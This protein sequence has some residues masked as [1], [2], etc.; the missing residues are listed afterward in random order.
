MPKKLYVGNLSFGATEDSIKT[1]FTQYG[2]VVSVKIIT[3]S[4]SGRSRGFG[5]VEME[6]AD[7]AIAA[8]NNQQ[9]EGRTLTV[10]VAREKTEGGRS[11][12]SGGFGGGSRGGFGGGRDNRNGGGG[13]GGGGNG[14]GG[15]ERW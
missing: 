8:L 13:N 2:E 9:F 1:L 3:D 7:D 15:R 6:N 10:N 5:F 4:M 11:G 14:G 12:G